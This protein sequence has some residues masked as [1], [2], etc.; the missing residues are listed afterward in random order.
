MGLDNMIRKRRPK[1]AVIEIRPVYSG[2]SETVV[3]Q[4][5]EI[6]TKIGCNISIGLSC[7]LIIVNT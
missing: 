6:H 2:G 4:M 1:I 5:Q 3:E 7:L